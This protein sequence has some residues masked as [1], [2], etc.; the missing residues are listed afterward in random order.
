M[1][2]SPYAGANEFNLELDSVEVAFTTLSRVA[3]GGVAEPCEF[4]GPSRGYLSDEA[5][6]HIL[7]QLVGENGDTRLEQNI[8]AAQVAD[9]I[10][11]D[12]AQA[13]YHFAVLVTKIVRDLPVS[14]LTT[15]KEAHHD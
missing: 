2:L 3:K 6:A 10:G 9:I 5:F 12:H 14:P 1:S 8:R 11:P 4:F 15:Q 13:L 7:L